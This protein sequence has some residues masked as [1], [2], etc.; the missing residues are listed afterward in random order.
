VPIYLAP[1]TCPNFAD[2]AQIRDKSI[3]DYHY[4]V[5]MAHKHLTDNKPTTMAAIR[6]P[7]ATVDQAKVEGIADKAKFFKHQLF[8][9]SIKD[10]LQDK[11]LEAQKETFAQSLKLARELESIKNNH[12]HSQRIAMVKAELQLEEANTIAWE[13]LTEDELE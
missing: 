5:Q 2:L 7:G 6:L 11:V 13:I 8:L 9:T 4:C 1:T 3:N 10:V 12:K